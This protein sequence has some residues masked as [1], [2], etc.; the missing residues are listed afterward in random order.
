MSRH[1][2]ISATSFDPYGEPVFDDRAAPMVQGDRRARNAAIAIFWILALLLIAGRVYVSDQ[3]LG[4]TVAAT[5]A[6][7]ASFVAAIR[8]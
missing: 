1:S 7:V 5:Q 6:Q 4:E 3:S 8:Q 2:E